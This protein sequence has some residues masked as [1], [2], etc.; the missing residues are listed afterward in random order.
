MLLEVSDY[1][2]SRSGMILL[3]CKGYAKLGNS[4]NKFNTIEITL[5]DS[6]GVIA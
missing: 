5:M 3:V 1:Q 6:D 2:L 4:N